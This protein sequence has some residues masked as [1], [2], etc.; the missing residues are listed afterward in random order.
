MARDNQGLQI[1]LIIF[2]TLAVILGATTW[3]FFQKSTETETKYKTA[4][5]EKEE[6]LRKWARFP[7]RRRSLK[8]SLPARRLRRNTRIS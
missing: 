5:E 2:V 4:V 6:R 3:Y 7:K 8:S 1:A